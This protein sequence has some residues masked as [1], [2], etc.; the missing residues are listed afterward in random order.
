MKKIIK[1]GFVLIII[2]LLTYLYSFTS[3]SAL[4]DQEVVGNFVKQFGIFAPLTFMVIYIGTSLLFIPGTPFAILGGVLFGTFLGTVYVVLAS[5]TAAIIAFLI[6][7][8]IAQN[9]TKPIK[10]KLISALTKRCEYHCE[11]HGFRT[12]L[13]LRLLYLPFIPL[14]YAAGF[15]KKAK[16]KDFVLATF[17]ANIITSFSLVYFGSNLG[18]GWQA[19]LIPLVLIVLTLLIPRIVKRLQKR[20][21][22]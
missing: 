20:F 3:F 7:K 5:C 14:S 11:E 4:F 21:K 6:A 13:I 1:I 15:V 19:L 17:F 2:A 22:N 9:R 8:K 18:K 12:F 10:N 16:L